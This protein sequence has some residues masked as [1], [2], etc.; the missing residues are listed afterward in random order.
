MRAVGFW[1]APW[2]RYDSFPH[3]YHLIDPDW[4]PAQR[5][6]VLAHLRAGAEWRQFLSLKPCSLCGER[7]GNTYVSDGEWFWPLVL[8]HEVER[9]G[10]RLPDEFVAAAQAGTRTPFDPEA[11]DADFTWWSQWTLAHG[12]GVTVDPGWSPVK[13]ALEDQLAD[14]GHRRCEP[15][16]WRSDGHD[17][18]LCREQG[19]YRLIALRSGATGPLSNDLPAL[20]DRFGPPPP[21]PPLTAAEVRQWADELTIRRGLPS[22]V[23]WVPDDDADQLLATLAS[24]RY[25]ATTLTSGAGGSWQEFTRD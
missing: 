3:P 13:A 6:A 17:A 11:Q 15:L 4:D 10:L 25:E 22:V 24:R 2:S 20:R 16:A 7:T 21:R 19:G 18:V 23:L 5:A 14:M 9:H 8:A 1:W 12:A